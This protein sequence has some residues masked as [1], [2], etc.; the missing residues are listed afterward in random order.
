MFAP[1]CYPP[2]GAEA[3][4]TAKLVLAM[5][6]AGW[7]VKV[8]AQADFSQFYPFSNNDIW[9]LLLPVIENIEGINAKSFTARY[10][11][12]RIISRLRSLLWV[13]KAFRAGYAAFK[14]N[15]CDFILSRATPQYG[16]LPALIL[17]RITKTPWIANWSDPLP[18]KKAPPPYGEGHNASISIFSQQYYR[19]VFK[20]AD[21][22]TFPCERL[23]NYY[24]LMA[25]GIK[26]KSSVI[27]HITLQNITDEIREDKSLFTICHT[28]G[29]ALRNPF[30]FLEGLNSFIKEN[31]LS[32]KVRMIFVG[33]DSQKLVTKVKEMGLDNVVDIVGAKTYEETLSIAASSSVLVVIEAKSEEGIFFPSKFVDFVQTGRP[34]L[35]VSPIPGTLHDILTCYGGGLAVDNCS[36][37][38]VFYALNTLY[39][40]W[41]KD[42]LTAIYGSGKLLNRFSADYVISEYSRIFDELGKRGKNFS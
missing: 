19:A 14:K 36:T 9:K 10:L 34:I 40:A 41:Q 3:I 7:Q 1:S 18:P 22:H 17:N 30:A 6:G 37:A 26:L 4:V 42:K 13:F 16:H 29:L 21:W 31:N 8:I 28:G 5:I 27:P 38:A 23:M 24:W 32:E 12:E 35:A 11:P 39:D 20:Y 25:P 2:S 33:D 15:Q